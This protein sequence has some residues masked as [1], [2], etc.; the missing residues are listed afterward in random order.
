M[1]EERPFPIT[2]LSAGDKKLTELF[3]ERAKQGDIYKCWGCDFETD[4][5]DEFVKHF[6]KH[7]NDFFKGEL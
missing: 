4:S 7:I 6:Q 2:K 5:E 1:S 3:V